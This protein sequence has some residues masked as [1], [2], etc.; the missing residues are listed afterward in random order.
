M[1]CKKVYPFL[2]VFIGVFS[3]SAQ[4]PTVVP[5]EIRAQFNGQ[6]DYKVIGNT[7]NEFDNQSNPP[8]PCQMLTQS[9]ATLNLNPNQNVVA[10][11]LY[12]SGI[13]DGTLNSTIQLN[14]FD[15]VADEVNVVD[16]EQ[17]GFNIYFGSFKDVTS[18]ILQEGNTVYTLENLNLNPI[19]NNY[20][21]SAIYHSGWSLLVIYED[22]TLPTQQ[23]NLYDGF[24]SVYGQPFNPTSSATIDIEGLNVVDTQNARLGFLAWNGNPFIFFNESISFN[25]N[26]LS[27][28]PLNPIDNP[29]NGTNSYTGANDLYNMDLDAFDISNFIQV[30]DTQASLT[31]S[32]GFNRFIQN[33]VTVIRS[34]LPD[35]QIE[36]LAF[37]GTGDCDERDF[38]IETVVSNPESSDILPANTPISFFVLDSNG[39]EVLLDTFFTQ[40]DIPINGSETQFLDITIPTDIPDDTTLIVKVNTLA[41]GSNPVNENNILNNTFEQELNLLSSP[42]PIAVQDLSQCANLSEVLYNL[43]DAFTATPNPDETFTFHLA[44]NEAENNLN[45]I[46]DPQNYTPTNAL[47][48]IFIRQSNANCFVVGSFMLETLIPPQI[49]DPTPLSKCDTTSDQSGFANFDL[50]SKI[51]EITNNNPDYDVQFFLTQAEAEDLTITNGLSSPYTNETAFS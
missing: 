6:F 20:C 12:W 36:L 32:S 41:D 10:A 39:D 7:H 31:F 3:L 50:T 1:F 44:Q 2:L 9:S 5:L 8:P 51:P 43:E 47:E 38:T 48:T 45:P 40:N 4:V 46:A 15:I 27:N 28:P 17:N 11:Y 23:V 49:N 35:A 37:P 13:G 34:E 30:G 19:I 14:G 16:P 18:L 29:F 25:S 42:E 33:V 22:N 26:L 24:A 21:S